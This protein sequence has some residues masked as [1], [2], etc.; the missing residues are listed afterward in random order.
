MPVR[1]LAPRRPVLLPVLLAGLASFGAA[2]AADAAIR[3]VN[4][5]QNLPIASQN[6]TTWTLAF[7]SLTSALA[8][9][10][11]GDQIWVA[12]G[13]YV[14]SNTASRFATFSLSKQLEIY[15]GF[16]P[17][18]VALTDRDPAA[19]PT[20]LSGDL[21]VI[22]DTSDNCFR[23]VQV[24]KASSIDGFTIRD[25]NANNAGP[26]FTSGTG[27]FITFATNV[28]VRN[29]RFTA[30]AAT[31]RGAGVQCLST[32][33]LFA[34]CVFDGNVAN[35]AG[36]ALDVQ[37]ASSTLVNC[38]FFG[39]SGL[40]GAGAFFLD[41]DGTTLQNCV[42]SGNTAAQGGGAIETSGT[43][44]SM[45]NCTFVANK[46]ILL[47]GGAIVQA[48]SNGVVAIGNCVF[49]KHRGAIGTRHF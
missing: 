42:F 39:N 35:N 37:Q 28:K 25:G 12:E 33:A 30:N 19:Y 3:F 47:P 10:L 32:V 17:G 34:G 6:G 24:T 26:G 15:G 1:S 38:G 18:A 48:F 41:S 2:S 31:S 43:D 23:V 9:S 11:D 13:T 29:C 4:A 8:V 16:L 36:G 22:G 5:A 27:M 45:Q 40:G 44:A 46:A 14:P 21:G 7:K 49:Q 20:I